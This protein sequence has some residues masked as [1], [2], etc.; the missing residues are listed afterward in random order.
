M[1]WWYRRSGTAVDAVGMFV[2]FMVLNVSVSSAQHVITMPESYLR[3]PV[4]STFGYG[5]IHTVGGLQYAF[6]RC[7][8]IAELA[9]IVLIISVRS[10]ASSPDSDSLS[11]FVTNAFTRLHFGH[12]T[13]QFT[14]RWS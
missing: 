2:V 13:L 5:V 7:E 11:G 14:R 12:F 10:I 3:L 6:S 9:V 4:R 1:F 8:A